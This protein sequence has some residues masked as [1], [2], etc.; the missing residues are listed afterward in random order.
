MMNSY[1]ETRRICDP[2]LPSQSYLTRDTGLTT[3]L[4]P[5]QVL[6][7]EY[8]VGLM[9]CSLRDWAAAT[10]AFERIITFPSRDAGVSK[11]MVEAHKKW[12]LTS[13]LRS[14][15]S[16]SQP[17]LVSGPTSRTFGILSKHYLQIAEHFDALDVTALRTAVTEHASSFGDDGNEGLV[18]EILATF[19]QWQIYFLRDVYAKVSIAELRAT[20]YNADTGGHLASDAAIAD[21]VRRMI[22]LGMLDAAIHEAE[23]GRPAYLEFLPESKSATSEAEYARALA[24]SAQRLRQLKATLG[25][26]DERLVMGKEYARFQLKEQQRREKAGRDDGRGDP[27]GFDE[28]IEDEDLMGGTMSMH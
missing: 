26:M 3:S 27:S 8:L 1:S 12:V 18:R 17:A 6:E 22:S 14:G 2:S 4:R 9:F 5:A 21:L 20:T 19:Q 28:Q 7:Y 11:V 13:L 10:A 24:A 23:G 25:T 15:K 16:A